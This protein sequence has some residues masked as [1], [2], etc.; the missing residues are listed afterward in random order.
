MVLS[1]GERQRRL[2]VGEAEETRLLAIQIGL[3]H[4]FGTGRAKS[5]GKAVIDGRQCLLDRHGHRHALA[6]G[7]PI[8]LD[9]DRRALLADI[10]FRRFGSRET[11]VRAG[12]DIVAG[13]DILGETLGAFQLGRRLG[14]AKN[15]KTRRAQIIRKPGHQRRFRAD[16]DEIDHLV[17]AKPI[18]AW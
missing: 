5:A 10:G 4:H 16:D 14:G 8:G 15:G 2:A 18:T 7:K 9:D 13:A 12:R 17:A 11:L 6:G 1:G 3:H